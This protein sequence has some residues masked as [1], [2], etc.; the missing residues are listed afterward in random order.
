MTLNDCYRGLRTLLE[1]ARVALA[2]P[3]VERQRRRSSLHLAVSE[4]RRR[5]PR[6]PARSL[7]QRAQLRRAIAFV[8]ARML[9]GPNC[10]RRSL[11]EMTLDRGAAN[12][13]LL[14]GFVSGGGPKSGHAW[15][16]SEPT[17]QRFDAV[18]AL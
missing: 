7:E 17:R 12:E 8:D 5:S 11:L 16:E 4:A 1:M 6:S 18:V 14:A 3:G 2:V 10:V 15:L 13:K 9:A